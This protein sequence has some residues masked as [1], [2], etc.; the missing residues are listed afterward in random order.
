MTALPVITIYR[1][2]DTTMVR[3]YKMHIPDSID[4]L[5]EL[6]QHLTA[7]VPLPPNTINGKG[8]RFLYSLTGKP[9]WRVKECV[10][11][12]T[13]VISTGPGFLSRHRGITGLAGGPA[14]D[15]S[16]AVETTRTEDDT[17][18]SQSG[19]AA[20]RSP[21]AASSPMPV[22]QP[23][24]P[25]RD[26]DRRPSQQSQSQ[27]SQQQQQQQQQRAS[28]TVPGR[29]SINIS[30]GSVERG[31]SAA[32]SAYTAG[33]SS[34]RVVEVPPA[35]HTAAPQAPPLS[36]A[37]KNATTTTSSPRA[38]PAGNMGLNY[39]SARPTQPAH[40]SA[41]RNE[42]LY[43]GVFLPY[44]PAASFLRPDEVIDTQQM[45]EGTREAHF[46]VLLSRKWPAYQRLR[47][48]PP[49]A[50]LA[51]AHLKRTIDEAVTRFT[52]ERGGGVRAH[53][54]RAIVSGPRYSGVSTTAALFV[55]ELVR[56]WGPALPFE[57]HL[58][59]PLDLATVLQ[60]HRH[61]GDSDAAANVRV[62]FQTVFRALMDSVAVQ[63][64]ALRDRT[65]VFA[66]LWDKLVTSAQVPNFCEYTQVASLVGIKVLSRWDDF[67]RAVFPLLSAAC[68]EYDDISSS[69]KSHSG[70]RV[71]PDEGLREAVLDIV[72]YAIP[73]EIA[74]SLQFSGVF[75]VLDGLE[76]LAGGAAA[77]VS[78]DRGIAEVAGVLKPIWASAHDAAV[79]AWPD[80][81]P[82][83]SISLPRTSV[84]VSTLG[85]LPLEV[86]REECQLPDAVQCVDNSSNNSSSSSDRSFTID[87]FAGCPGYLAVLK[88]LVA[89]YLGSSS[90]LTTNQSAFFTERKKELKSRQYAIRIDSP[91]ALSALSKLEKKTLRLKR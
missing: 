90:F 66:E 40:G 14:I 39:S 64:P 26:A 10:E 38:A 76:A 60:H 65:L 29:W 79:V 41:P 11:A 25:S 63:R 78:S 17:P 77:A 53:P 49:S 75:Y 71:K 51:P 48:T 46:H 1:N 45:E 27:P 9:L 72:F 42:L 88:T 80:G 52:A 2:D 33:R 83:T 59:L 54:F 19:A 57:N 73:N 4:T 5:A 62:L 36:P 70:R 34:T 13:I 21:F 35:A 22:P 43:K 7:H 8:F 18:V 68:Q 12:Q 67:A 58:L 30:G 32:D 81:V 50:L 16:P 87:I 24:Q 15:I 44:P 37:P 47:K 86:A 69:S 28:S 20:V 82:L 55:Q 3:P 31:V 74:S 23:R 56:Q 89:P 6:C 91:D 84:R 85:L 61:D